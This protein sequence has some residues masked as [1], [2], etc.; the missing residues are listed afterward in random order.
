MARE[1]TGQLALL[2]Y[3]NPLTARVGRE[4]FAALPRTPG[5]YVMY[6]LSNHVIYVGKAKNLRARLASYR[7]ARPHQV[8]RKVIR[9]IHVIDEIRYETCES[10]AHALLRENEL[11]RLHRPLFNV[12]N[13]RP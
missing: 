6:G 10:E 2:P 3:Q 7:R 1:P 9:L 8:S 5:V 4:F 13:T 12:V 11:L